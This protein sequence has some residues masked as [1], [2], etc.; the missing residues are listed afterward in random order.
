MT[1]E[2]DA[3]KGYWQAAEKANDVGK[4]TALGLRRES[5]VEE[6]TKPI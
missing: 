4:M 5:L 1:K 3:L 2:R 6:L